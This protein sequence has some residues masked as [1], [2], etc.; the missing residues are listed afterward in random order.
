MCTV[1][2]YIHRIEGHFLL[3]YRKTFGKI[4]QVMLIGGGVQPKANF[5]FISYEHQI[6]DFTWSK[7]SLQ[8]NKNKNTI[9]KSIAFLHSYA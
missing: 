3:L 8:K 6:L 9:V 5:Q 2:Y 7:I 4:K 1:C